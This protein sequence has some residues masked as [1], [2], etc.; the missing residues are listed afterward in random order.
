[1]KRLR[2]IIAD[3]TADNGVAKRHALLDAIC[4]DDEA[5]MKTA[6]PEAM[7]A[8]DPATRADAFWV[9]TFLS[10]S[11]RIGDEKSRE[12]AMR[13]GVGRCPQLRADERTLIQEIVS[14][15]AKGKG[16]GLV[17]REEP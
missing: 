9:R 10:T 1:M 13:D 6:L 4:R 11:L 5:A 8:S 7:A 3:G 15:A 14:E 17:Q 16:T 12:L 2:Q